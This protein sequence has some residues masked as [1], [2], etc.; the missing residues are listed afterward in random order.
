V[1]VEGGTNAATIFNALHPS[2]RAELAPTNP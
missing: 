1:H 2:V